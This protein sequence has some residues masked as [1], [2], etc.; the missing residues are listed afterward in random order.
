MKNEDLQAI[1]GND[2]A[3]LSRRIE[4]ANVTQSGL[5][6]SRAIAE[7]EER[8]WSKPDNRAE[9]QKVFAR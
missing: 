1:F 6:V 4:N 5:R 9:W 3:T 7:H 8:E 2:S